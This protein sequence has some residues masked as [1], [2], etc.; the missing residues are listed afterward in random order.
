M[1]GKIFLGGAAGC[2]ILKRRARKA[3]GWALPIKGLRRQTAVTRLPAGE[4][5]RCEG[6]KRL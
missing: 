6:S 1:G 3:D 2:H 4:S 5:K